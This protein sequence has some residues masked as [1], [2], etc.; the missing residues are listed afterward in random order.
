M[1]TVSFSV[2]ENVKQVFNEVF[3]GQNKSAIIAGLMLEAVERAQ[4]EQRSR[5]A[6]QSILKR[7]KHAPTITEKKFRTARETGRP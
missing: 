2:P 7:R 1:S 5:E 4:R 6:Y 3:K